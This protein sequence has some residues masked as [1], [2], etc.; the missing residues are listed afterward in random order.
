MAKGFGKSLRG[1]KSMRTCSR[2]KL[3]EDDPRKRWKA[4]I[5]RLFT[6]LEAALL[7]QP[8]QEQAAAL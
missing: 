4:V 8:F 3:E 7:G 6:Q 2:F 5:A 1:P